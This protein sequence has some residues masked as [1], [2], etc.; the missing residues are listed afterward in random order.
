SVVLTIL[1]VIELEICNREHR[2]GAAYRRGAA[3]KIS[4]AMV[5]V[6]ATSL[7]FSLP[8]WERKSNR[9]NSVWP[10]KVSKQVPRFDD[11]DEGRGWLTNQLSFMVTDISPNAHCLEPHGVLIENPQQYLQF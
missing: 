1:A 9:E 5:A 7:F 10:R 8:A 3:T 11:K 6:L 2:R 4:F